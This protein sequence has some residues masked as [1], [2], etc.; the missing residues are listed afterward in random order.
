[1]RHISRTQPKP[2]QSQF[3]NFS[4]D[5]VPLRR[6]T[7]ITLLLLL[8][9][10]CMIPQKNIDFCKDLKNCFLFFAHE[11]KVIKEISFNDIRA[12]TKCSMNTNLQILFFISSF[13]N[14]Y[15]KFEFLVYLLLHCFSKCYVFFSIFLD[16]R[17][18]F[19]IPPDSTTFVTF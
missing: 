19:S 5:T 4:C 3:E 13:L 14:R 10:I 16:P 6:D 15:V 2:P 12:I 18:D 8:I 1:M 11:D 9:A 7:V 17:E